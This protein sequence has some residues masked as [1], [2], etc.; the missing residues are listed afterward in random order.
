MSGKGNPEVLAERERKY[1]AI[2]GLTTERN[3]LTEQID[4]RNATRA[5]ALA[6]ARELTARRDRIDQEIES[7][8]KSA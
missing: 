5:K 7:L 2:A 3:K 6:D 4:A 8:R 1:Q